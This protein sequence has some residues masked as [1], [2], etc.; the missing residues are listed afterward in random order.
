MLFVLCNVKLS[1][2]RY[3]EMNGG[4]ADASV[5]ATDAPWEPPWIQS[6]ITGIPASHTAVRQPLL[7]VSC[8][9]RSRA[10]PCP[11]PGRGSAPAT[12][13]MVGGVSERP[14]SNLSWLLVCDPNPPPVGSCRLAAARGGE[15]APPE[16]AWHGWAIPGLKLGWR[17]THW[18]PYRRE[19]GVWKVKREGRLHLVFCLDFGWEV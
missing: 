14:A 4:T 2:Y 19:S 6:M 9:W 13:F 11:A 18:C 1:K 10:P 17:V 16:I 12:A 7:K 5:S 3:Y 15:G 8:A